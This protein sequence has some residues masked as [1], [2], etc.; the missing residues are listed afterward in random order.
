MPHISVAAQGDPPCAQTKAL[1]L[2]PALPSTA[3]TK[4]AT[5]LWKIL[6]F[7]LHGCWYLFLNVPRTVR[8]EKQQPGGRMMRSVTPTPWVIPLQNSCFSHARSGFASCGR[9]SVP[10][11][12]EMLPQPASSGAL[13][14]LP[15][16]VNLSLVLGSWEQAFSWESS[17][18]AP[19]GVTEI[20]SRARSSLHWLFLNIPTF[21]K[22]SLHPPP[23]G[24]SCSSLFSQG[25]E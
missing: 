11:G 18:S 6:G 3:H 17:P 5:I 13:C 12:G 8:P 20:L 2:D 19:Q 10:L 25:L 7:S 4:S 22:S 16:F 21:I 1:E 14:C 9:E 15:G 23:L 24:N